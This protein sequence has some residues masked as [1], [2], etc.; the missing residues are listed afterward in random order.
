MEF[1]MLYPKPFDVNMVTR[2]VR[3]F[4]GNNWVAVGD[5]QISSQKL[6]CMDITMPDMQT[7]LANRESLDDGTFDW[8]EWGPRMN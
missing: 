7:F 8:L 4:L 3:F 5:I 2:R 6:F 1:D